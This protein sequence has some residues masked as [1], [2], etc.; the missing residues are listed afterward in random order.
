MPTIETL[1]NTLRWLAFAGVIGLAGCAAPKATLPP[2][3]PPGAS[4]EALPFVPPVETCN[5]TAA[6]VHVL[7]KVSTPQLEQQA[8]RLASATSVRTLLENQP[9]TKEY[10][11]GRLNLVVKAQRVITRVYCG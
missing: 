11:F 5:A 3:P 4:L 8:L 6:S 9:I 1:P 7:G 2:P 10:G